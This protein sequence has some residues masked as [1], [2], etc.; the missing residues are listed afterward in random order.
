MGGQGKGVHY[1]PNT[2]VIDDSFPFISFHI[3]NNLEFIYFG[4][5]TSNTR[6]PII[7]MKS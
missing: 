4:E 1:I 2:Q 3:F 6:K 5:L 7:I